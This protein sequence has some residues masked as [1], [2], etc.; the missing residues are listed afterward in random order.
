MGFINIKTLFDYKQCSYP[1]WLFY[2]F[3]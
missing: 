2:I 3:S 1:Q